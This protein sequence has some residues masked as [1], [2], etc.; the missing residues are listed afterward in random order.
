[1][2]LILNI[3]VSASGVPMIWLFKVYPVFLIFFYSS[4][5]I[6]NPKNLT[7]LKTN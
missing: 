3:Q 1:M 5:L 6:F 4:I 7:H 2:S